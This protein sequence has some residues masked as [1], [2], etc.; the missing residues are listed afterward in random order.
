M[1]KADGA[2]LVALDHACRPQARTGYLRFQTS[3][4]DGDV[5]GRIGVFRAA[6]QLLDA[7]TLDAWAAERVREA[8]V[9]FDDHLIVPRLEPE[10]WRAVFWFRQ[11]CKAL[12]RRVWE[13]VYV[14]QDYGVPVSFQ[15][16]SEPGCICYSDRFQIAAIPR[17]GRR[18]RSLERKVAGYGWPGHGANVV[19]P[20]GDEG[21]TPLPS[22][23]PRW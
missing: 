18:R 7:D 11:E 5:P 4:R 14:L 10:H 8:C 3:L 22:A 12:V 16:S 2:A 21:S 15:H 19:L 13:L 23:R 9:W 17:R 6:G 20:R 1:Q